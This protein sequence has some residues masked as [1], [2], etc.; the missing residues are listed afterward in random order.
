[1]ASMRSSS[2]SMALALLPLLVAAAFFIPSLLASSASRTLDDHGLDGEALLMLGRFHGWMA[3]HGRSYATEEEKLRR[4]EVYRSNMA[5]I[6]AANRD[7]RMS[8]RLGETPFTDL[9]HDEFMAMYGGNNG[10]PTSEK[11]EMMMI[12]TRAG[13]VH[14]GGGV[15]GGDLHQLAAVDE[16]EPPRRANLTALLPPSVDWRAEGVVTPVGF[17]AW[18]SSCWAFVAAATIESAK[19]IS[20]GDPPPVLSEQQLVDCDTLDK[21]CGGG[22]M[23][24]AFKWVIQNGGITSAA[25]Y[26]YTDKNGTCQEGKPAEATLSS[27]KLLPRGDEEAIMEA[28]AR[29]PVAV[30][31]D[32]NDPCFQHYIDGVYDAGCSISGV[33][34]KGACKTA[35]NHALALVGYGTK[36]DGTKYWIG[37]NSWSAKWG[38]NGFVYVLRDSPPLGLCGLAVRPS[39]PII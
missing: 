38:E 19:A 16:E 27:Y 12:T 36:P 20:T 6:E 33:Y 25:A 4:F 22:W 34:T 35:Q 11:E 10:D 31:F 3:A 8:Y 17:N 5:F 29:Q 37:K 1:M 18:C 2:S 7:S 26:P 28:V 32:H 13:P 9:T 39:F 24:R 23:D 21:G 15:H 14:E 30:A